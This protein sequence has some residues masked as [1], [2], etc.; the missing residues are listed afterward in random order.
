M[1]PLGTSRRDS[2]AEFVAASGAPIQQGLMAL[3]GPE[4]GRD[5][6]SEALTYGWE[7]WERVGA[8][9]NPAG[10]LFTVGRN[11]GRRLARRA[12]FPAPPASAELVD[13]ESWVEPG[14]SDAV[15][16]LSER[17]RVATLLVHGGEWTYTEVAELL[18]VD[19]GT[20]KKH[21]DRG[22]DKLRATLEVHLDA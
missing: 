14:L 10:Y 4:L 18:G 5:A 20:V 7:Q 1:R 21:A 13:G 22:L 9:D 17:Q 19:R 16:A 15:A 6:A 11:R 2:F 12:T 8:M 3:L